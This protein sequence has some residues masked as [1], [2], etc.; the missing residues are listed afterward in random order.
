MIVVHYSMYDMNEINQITKPVNENAPNPGPISP[1]T[2]SPPSA[3]PLTLTPVVN[4][5]IIQNPCF[6]M[7]YLILCMNFKSNYKH[8]MFFIL[9]LEKKQTGINV[10]DLADGCDFVLGDIGPRL[11]AFSFTGFVI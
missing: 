10:N 9:Y 5:Y 3:R 6:L 11:G 4:C 7:F 1:N 2:E 8:G